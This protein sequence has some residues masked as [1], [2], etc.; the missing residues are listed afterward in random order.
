MK[1]V[2]HFLGNG[3]AN[4]N[5]K[6]RSK[7]L[8]EPNPYL[9]SRREWN[10]QIDRAFSSVHL[11]RL[12]ALACLLI[13]LAAVAGN[14]YI[15]SQSKFV[16]Y[17]MQVDRT[18]EVTVIGPAQPVSNASPLVIRSFLSSFI[19]SARLV[20]PDV[21]VQRQAIFKVYGMLRQH[22]PATAKMNEYLGDESENSPF[23]RAK[24]IMVSTDKFV[25]LPIS[26]TSWQLEWEETTRGRDGGLLSKTDNRAN[27]QIYIDPPGGSALQSDIQKNP[28]GIFVKDF[29]WQQR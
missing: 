24:N 11:Y 2:K 27:L 12:I 9:N 16:P 28:I 4:G 14:V 7:S 23:K 19:A 18:G 5:G 1:F 10:S 15:G 25:V 26:G 20:T 29:S 8:F 6:E 21:D 22:D 13:A 3:E 17:L